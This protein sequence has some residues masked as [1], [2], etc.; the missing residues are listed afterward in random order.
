V[1]GTADFQL[2]LFD[3]LSAGTQI[4]ST[5][6]V[7]NVTV[8]QGAF[9]VVL[10]FGA[11]AFSGDKRWLDITVRSPAGSGSF[12][13]LTPRQPLTAAPFALK[14]RG[15]DGHS[16]DASDGSPT[17]VVFVGAD[18][19]VGIGTTNPTHALHFA[20]TVP[21]VNV[22]DSDSQGAAPSRATSRMQPPKATNS[23]TP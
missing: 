15:V 21:I 14:T 20:A 8:V 12:T 2:K 7:N 17:D 11:G 5:Q 22:Q 3:S 6:A 1:N 23:G 16:L 4:G 10:D 18:G 19:K 9:T 13:P